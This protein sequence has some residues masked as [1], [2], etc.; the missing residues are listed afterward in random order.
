M[1]RHCQRLRDQ[2]AII[3]RYEADAQPRRVL[4]Y[5]ELWIQVE[6]LAGGLK[7]LGLQKGDRVVAMLPNSPENLIASIAVVAIGGI[8]SACSPDMGEQVILPRFEAIEPKFLFASDGYHYNGKTVS[9]QKA[10]DFL[11]KKLPGLQNTIAVPFLTKVQC[12]ARSFCYS[13]SN[14]FIL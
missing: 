1:L 5:G 6:H 11:V 8:W 3:F 2:P 4:T 10:V 14:L 7:K 9:C 13:V 12:S